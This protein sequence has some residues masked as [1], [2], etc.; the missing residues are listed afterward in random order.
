M[1]VYVDSVRFAYRGMIMCHMWA[2]SDAELH[3]FAGQLGMS[4]S[5]HQRPPKASWSHYD[6]SAGRKRQALALGAILTDR[7]GALEHV[8]KLQGDK[9]TLDRIAAV[10]SK[11]RNAE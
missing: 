9:V 1:A 10:R 11:K 7:Y 4:R 5:W 6:C 8:A 2:D 3:S